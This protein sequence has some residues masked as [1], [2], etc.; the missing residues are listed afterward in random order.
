MFLFALLTWQLSTIFYPNYH[1][2]NVM[3]LFCLFF[4]IILSGDFNY[5]LLLLHNFLQ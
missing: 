5:I 3:Q 1:E 2:R 4:Y